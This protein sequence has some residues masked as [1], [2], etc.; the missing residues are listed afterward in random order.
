M[1]NE[2]VR[3]REIKKPKEKETARE[4]YFVNT[5]IRKRIDRCEYVAQELSSLSAT[6]GKEKPHGHST[7]PLR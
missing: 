7:L 3:R 6:V 4:P 5:P 1:G 2:D